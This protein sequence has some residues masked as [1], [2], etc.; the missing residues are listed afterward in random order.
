MPDETLREKYA[1]AA[2]TDLGLYYCGYRDRTPQHTY[3]PEIRMHFLLVLVESGE[4]VLQAHGA[5]I[6]F[7]A[8]QLLVMFPGERIAYRATTPWS[9]RWIGVNGSAPE[10][11]LAAVGVTR[12]MPVCRPTQFAALREIV[13]ELYDLQYDGALRTQYRVQTLLYRFFAELLADARPSPRPDP[14]ETALRM[15]RYNL[16]GDL[17]VRT[18]ADSVFLDESYFGRLFCARMGVTPKA[19]MQRQRVES[20]KTLLRTTDRQIQEIA[21]AVGFCDPLYFSRVFQKLEGLTPTAFRRKYQN[22][23]PDQNPIRNHP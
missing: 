13:T 21:A 19:Y 15:I 23:D 12:A 1:D 4:A 22:R 9:I 16:T 14:I 11:A 7:G 6:P 8:G 3:G 17:S 20:A 10:T 2:C 5:E 18:L